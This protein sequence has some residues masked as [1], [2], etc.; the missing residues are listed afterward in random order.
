M[1]WS[2]FCFGYEKS[3]ERAIKEDPTAS[4]QRISSKA[5]DLRGSGGRRASERKPFR[6][7]I[8]R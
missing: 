2:G 7:L 5:V 6:C 4:S 3:L 8:E 1:V